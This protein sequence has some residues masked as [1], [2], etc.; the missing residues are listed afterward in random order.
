GPREVTAVRLYLTAATLTIA[1]AVIAVAALAGWILG[2]PALTSV[3]PGLVTMKVNSAVALLLSAVALWI[4]RQWPDAR[5]LSWVMRTASALAIAIAVAAVAEHLAGWDLSVDQLFF[6]D[7]AMG[8]SSPGRM[9]LASA[10]G[11]LLV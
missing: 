4:Y 8:G 11:V 9:P 7:V 3:F 1:V 10:L 5:I 2:V 6:P